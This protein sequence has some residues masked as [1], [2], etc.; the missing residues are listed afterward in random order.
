MERRTAASR[1]ASTPPP[2][3]MFATAGLT[4]L[5]VT[6]SMPAVTPAVS[7]LP[8]QSSTRTATSCTPFATPYRP[9]P[10]VPATCVPWP[11][12]SSAD[13]PSTA[14]KPLAAV[15]AGE[16][17]YGRV[18]VGR[19]LE[20]DHIAAGDHVGGASVPDRALGRYARGRRIA[21]RTDGDDRTHRK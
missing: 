4:A 21:D 16:A 14:S 19:R 11:L 7:P 5:A 2:S 12:Q 18:N 6:Q 13:P 3:L 17:P 20:R 9:P 15:P 1:V 10:T 8:V